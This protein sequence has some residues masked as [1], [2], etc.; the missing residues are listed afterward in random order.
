M[1]LLHNIPH[2]HI[3]LNQNVSYH[4]LDQIHSVHCREDRDYTQIC[5]PAENKRRRHTDNAH[6]EAV[7]EKCNNCL[8]A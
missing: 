3:F 5:I 6:E 4:A 2:P 8:S 1:L 7:K